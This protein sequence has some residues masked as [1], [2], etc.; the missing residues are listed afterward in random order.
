[1]CAHIFEETVKEYSLFNL[2][3]G[4]GIGMS[5]DTQSIVSVVYIN[6]NMDYCLL[7]IND[8]SEIYHIIPNLY[9]NFTVSKNGGM[10]LSDTASSRKSSAE[11][12]V[13]VFK[14]GAE[15]DLTMGTS[16]NRLVRDVIL[17]GNTHTYKSL[18]VVNWVSNHMVFLSKIYLIIFVTR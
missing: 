10:L 12:I 17:E 2:R 4:L 8:Q 14:C 9:P 3:K 1:M 15:T 7:L 18:Y 6:R 11:S 5:D 13:R 16:K